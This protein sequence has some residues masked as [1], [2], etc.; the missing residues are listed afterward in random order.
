MANG[1]VYYVMVPEDANCAVL[2]EIG[3]VVTPTKGSFFLS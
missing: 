3:D 1:R 2:L